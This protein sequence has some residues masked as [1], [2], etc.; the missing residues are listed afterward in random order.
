MQAQLKLS[1][2][3]LLPRPSHSFVASWFPPDYFPVACAA[4]MLHGHPQCRVLASCLGYLNSVWS[5]AISAQIFHMLLLTT[6]YNSSK[7]L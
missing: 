1:D 4:T 5:F 6:S 2:A 7:L 3:T